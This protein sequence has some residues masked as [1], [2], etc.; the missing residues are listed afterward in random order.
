MQKIQVREYQQSMYRKIMDSS[1][2]N[3]LAVLPPGGGKSHI[4]GS[5]VR[6]LYNQGKS[7]GFL[8]HVDNLL[9]QAMYHFVNYGIPTNDIGFVRGDKKYPMNKQAP[10]QI[11]SIQTINRRKYYPPVD[12]WI[13]DEAHHS[14]AKSYVALLE[15]S[16]R[17]IGFTATPVKPLDHLYD[18]MV[19]GPK[20]SQLVSMGYISPVVVYDGTKKPDLTGVKVKKGDYEPHALSLAMQE[21]GLTGDAVQ[22]WLRHGEGRSTV[23]FTPDRAFSDNVLKAYRDAGVS[24][25]II[26]GSMGYAEREAKL[27]RFILKSTLVLINVK[28][29]D[30]GFDLGTYSDFYQLPAVDIGCVQDLAPTLS[31][32]K[33]T[34]I[35]GRCERIFAGKG[36]GILLDHAGNFHR[37]HLDR[38]PAW[39]L[40]EGLVTGKSKAKPKEEKKVQPLFKEKECPECF[41][42]WPAAKAVCTCG[43]RFSN[44]NNYRDE[45]LTKRKTTAAEQL[46]LD[47]R[48]NVPPLIAINNFLQSS[49]LTFIDFVNAASTLGHSWQWAFTQWRELNP[50]IVVP[51]ARLAKLL[52]CSSE[53]LNFLDVGMEKGQL[54]K[55]RYRQKT[56]DSFKIKEGSGTIAGMR[57]G[58]LVIDCGSKNKLVEPHNILEKIA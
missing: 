28:I 37:H 11:A 9:N 55:F 40:A 32:A 44:K 48:S 54:V 27:R 3:I 49:E 16:N 17:H 34:Q 39:S 15:Q 33:A 38:D 57:G 23:C 21:Q 46:T 5:I 7:V 22:N 29:F 14:I 51:Y 1:N 12:C 41:T 6:D 58:K 20:R 53:E 56:K 19:E 42:K 13:I 26:D 43:Y 35:K 2:K 4:F 24:A 52:N 47:L 50:E 8:A 31:Y 36:Y 25:E 18:E 10:V 45:W 30:E